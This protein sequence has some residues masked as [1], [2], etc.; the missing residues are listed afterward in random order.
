MNDTAIVLFL[1]VPEKGRIKT[2]LSKFLDKGFV[3]RLY[4]AFILDLLETVSD[5]QH[6]FLFFWPPEKKE[7]LKRWLG[8]KYQFQHQQ[9]TDIG[10]KMSHA[11]ESI[12]SKGFERII[13]MG[14]DI[15]EIDKALIND[16]VNALDGND[17]VIGPCEDGGY[18]LIGMNSKVFSDSIFKGIE[19]SGPEVLSETTLVFQQRNI[20]YQML[21]TLNDIDTIQ[22]FEALKQ[23]AWENNSIGS[24]TLR[25]LDPYAI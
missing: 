13:L 3:L 22:D 14:T 5:F 23:K 7:N 19:W 12:F 10:Q 20:Q 11:F 17:A 16:A 25:I 21:K 15:P 18:Y 4:K 1:R 9:G 2:R 24:H 6:L 8:T